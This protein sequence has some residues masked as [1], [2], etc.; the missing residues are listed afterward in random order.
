MDMVV[1]MSFDKKNLSGSLLFAL[2][3]LLNPLHADAQEE[4]SLQLKWK[5]A[6]QFA[7]FYIA[8][9]KGY[10]EEAGLNVRLIEGGPGKSPVTHVL[11]GPGHYSVSDTGII[12]ARAEGNP[13]QAL[14]AIFQHSPLA[15]AVKESSGIKTFEEL[16]GK[17]VMMQS[18]HMDAVILAAINK[19]GLT[20]DDF[21][22]LDTSFNILD[23][24]D[25]NTDAFSI[26]ITDQPH[27][28]ENLG[29]PYRILHPIQYGI[30]FY[31]D[32]LI[33]SEKE[34]D[35]YPERAEAF[36]QASLRGWAYALEHIDETIELI[37][38]KYHSQRLSPGQLY[39]EAEET[40]DMVLK[41]VVQI[42][43]MSQARWQK[44]I[45]IYTELGLITKSYSATE[46][47]YSKK[48][49]LT[50]FFKQ[51]QW[52]LI[53][54]IL[55][56]L[57]FIF[58]LYSIL[59]GKMVRSRTRELSESEIRFRTL[60]ANLP[61]V[62]YRCQCDEFWTMDFISN[63]IETISGFPASDFH[64]NRVRSFNSIIHPDDRDDVRKSVMESI[65]N[66]QSFSIEYRIICSDGHIRWLHEQ[67]QAIFSDKTDAVW[68]DGNLL[69]ITERKQ[70][71]ELKKSTAAI[72]EMV[73]KGKPLAHILTR[74]V[75]SYEA[76]YPD[77]RAS[78]LLLK[79][80]KLYKGAAP[81]LPEVYNKA[82]E[83][84]EIGTMVGSCGTAAF[85][86]KRVIV[87]D[88]EHDARWAAYTELVLPLGLRACW[89]EPVFSST[90]EVIGTFAMYYDHP[91]APG[92]DEL[93]DISNAAQLSAI[94]IE[95]DH[96]LKSLH[97]LS[98]AIEQ[99]A[100]VITITDQHGIIEYV[101]PAF[102]NITGY[103]AEEAIGKTPQLFR[104]ESYQP[105][106]EEMRNTIAQGKTWLGKVIEMKKDGSTYP[107]MLTISPIRDETG[108]ITHHVSVHEDLSRIQQL[109]E[110]FYQAQKMEAVGTLVGGIA[111]D[112]N[113]MLAGIT[114]N[115]YLARKAADG[116]VKI[117]EKLSRIE[118][119]SLRAA[120]M[121]K[122]LLTFANKDIVQK[123]SVP[124]TPFLKE[125]LKLHQVSVPEN[126]SLN[127]EIVDDMQVSGDITQLQQMLLNLITNARDAVVDVS[128]PRI[129][130][131]LE[132]YY[133]DPAFQRKHETYKQMEYAHLS[134]S[135]N[136]H[137]I[138]EK[139]LAHIY[140]PFYST[141]EVGKGTG[142]GLSMV[143][144]SLKSHDGFIEVDSSENC[145]TTFHIYLPLLKGAR[146]NEL[147]PHAETPPGHGETIL[148]VD[149]ETDVL[150][151]IGEVL[152]SLGYHL[153]KA[154]DGEAALTLFAEQSD[155]I[156]L[157]LTDIVMPKAGGF[158]LAARA[159]KIKPQIPVIFATGYDKNLATGFETELKN[160][161]T[162]NK[163]YS[164][165]QI[166]QTIRKMLD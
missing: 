146:Q 59:L 165:E 121:I 27:Q 31:G 157:I 74:I 39:F 33:T 104:D 47:L 61:G 67:G 46:M 32:I 3:L 24:I 137:G 23:L 54:G 12:L 57:L 29:M 125:T 37:Q 86:K 65:R 163:P 21:R 154:E 76:R 141:K 83:A 87:E 16:R 75:K 56:T 106:I 68:L 156:D 101:N 114:G 89:S 144:G 96:Y 49:T 98:Q 115:L 71:E 85:H 162:L 143:F 35:K 63:G 82:I 19:A 6:F 62:A 159:R 128:E 58:G 150:E 45:D 94:A 158:E 107:A 77:M 129:D 136:G 8:K 111:H 64:N 90:G 51:Y 34:L 20:A 126:V 81:S 95:R 44:I 113:N 2:L 26:Y 105:L 134:I 28:L 122:Q 120:D 112:F 135:D 80:G 11:S 18:G 13:V 84:L 103:S 17:R 123:S 66:R 9:E 1:T 110:Q 14:A 152:H 151:T 138:P 108:T 43:Y 132:Q 131:K 160:C 97:K 118:N 93:S 124:L 109:E 117:T 140:E 161:E 92:A 40:S 164:I 36:T 69:D 10:Y 15:L 7:G 142:L 70:S 116:Q 119:L 53:V 130:I 4:I 147:T 100:E 149:D 127:L 41:D 38:S 5:H 30:D 42:G 139:N 48:P 25:G 55:I 78:I 72:L 99:T 91:C 102:S 133:A 88:I 145:G 155:K 153:F 60:V 79:N 50:D 166:A 73:A 52:Q 22:R 148:L